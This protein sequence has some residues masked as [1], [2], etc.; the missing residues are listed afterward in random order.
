MKNG[1][2]GLEGGVSWVEFISDVLLVIFGSF[3]QSGE[4]HYGRGIFVVW[5]ICQASKKSQLKEKLHILELFS[6]HFWREKTGELFLLLSV[7]NDVK[8]APG[9]YTEIKNCRIGGSKH[10]YGGMFTE[11]LV[12]GGFK[13]LFYVH[14]YLR[15]WSNLESIWLM[16]CKRVATTN[17]FDRSNLFYVS[18]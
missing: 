11:P 14:P 1:R 6:L 8:E 16:F 13:H 15:K 17:C 12:A 2:L 5:N 7:P 3:L 9:I 18:V 4:R 10:D